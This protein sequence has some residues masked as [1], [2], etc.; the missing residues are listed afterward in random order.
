MDGRYY[1]MIILGII[2]ILFF[3]VQLL[4][5]YKVK[6]I[7]IK[8]IPVYIIL[9]FLLFSTA[10]YTGVFGTGF[11]GAERILAIILA[12]GIGTALFGAAVA[13]VVYRLCV[14]NISE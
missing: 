10:L 13:W 12:L 1:T 9:S 14:K 8:L 4:I 3:A 7:A 2:G 5:C 11:L 6:R